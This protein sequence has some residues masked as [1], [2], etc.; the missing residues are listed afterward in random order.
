MQTDLHVKRKKERS[1]LGV[2]EVTL[3]EGHEGTAEKQ[4]VSYAKTKEPK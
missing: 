1:A 4:I 2:V 3:I